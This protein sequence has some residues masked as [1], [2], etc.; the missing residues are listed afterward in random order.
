M[1]QKPTIRN[2]LTNKIPSLSVTKEE[3][4]KLF[5]LLQ[6]RSQA[7]GDLEVYNFNRGDQSDDEYNKSVETLKE[8]FKLKPTVVSSG[9][10]ELFGDFK[11]IFKS[12]NFPDDLISIYVNSE[13]PL[14]AGYNY[15]PANSFVLFLDFSKP[16]LFNLSF[17]PSQATPNGSNISVQGYDA[18]WTH[19]V[20][21]EFNNF[22][23][24]HPSKM[25]WL[26]QHSIYDLLVWGLGLPFGF[27][28]AYRSSSILDKIFSG[29][30]TFIL[31]GAYVYIF[32]A[33]LMIFRLLFHYSRWV[34]PLVEYKSARNKSVKH[35]VILGAITLGL[36]TTLIVDLIKLIF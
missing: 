19:G 13:I 6:E 35:Q 16:D 31:N 20:F 9:G 12:P 17:L 5:L 2:R 34:W 15:V 8:G 24:N 21:S 32:L 10:K 4:Y 33:S 14:T 22:I 29:V 23:K 18:T 1:E 3:I 36:L 28:M 26:H 27:W 25:T 30:S 11:D 7:A